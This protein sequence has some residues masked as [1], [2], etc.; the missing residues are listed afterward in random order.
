M[1][2]E[3][4]ERAFDVGKRAWPRVSLELEQFQRYLKRVLGEAPSWD[5]Q[6]H[7]ADL[8]LACGCAAGDG[9]AQEAFERELFP[10]VEAV[11]QR[12]DSDRRFVTAAMSALRARLFATDGKVVAYAARGGLSAWLSVFATRVAMDTVRERHRRTS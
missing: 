5:W 7:A 4:V 10:D 11:I 6:A 2:G 1:D 9:V 12:V 8:Y 3:A